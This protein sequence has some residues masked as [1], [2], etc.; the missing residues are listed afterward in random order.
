[1]SS[2]APEGKNVW[3]LPPRT[4]KSVFAVKSSPPSS[5]KRE[6]QIGEPGFYG[7][8]P[9]TKAEKQSLKVTQA[10]KNRGYL[11]TYTERRIPER[12]RK[13]SR[14]TWPTICCENCGREVTA[15][16]GIRGQYYSHPPHFIPGHEP[17]GERTVPVS[18]DP[19]LSV[20]GYDPDND[21]APF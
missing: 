11:C 16:Y 10:E 20:M 21:P 1:V 6:P 14:E 5:N 2:S 15:V 12:L 13:T 18:V 19:D 7:G 3:G 17:A 8:E 4:L 9:L